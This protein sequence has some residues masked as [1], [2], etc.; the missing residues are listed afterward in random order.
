MQRE[1][2]RRERRRHATARKHPSSPEW[3]DRERCAGEREMRDGDKHSNRGNGTSEAKKQGE[4]RGGD[5]ERERAR[6]RNEGRLRV[7]SEKRERVN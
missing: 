1:G 2:E 7:R 3:S 4:Q 6:A 5:R